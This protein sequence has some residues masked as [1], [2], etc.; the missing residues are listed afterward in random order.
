MRCVLLES[1]R[2][3]KIIALTFLVL[4]QLVFA[5]PVADY[6]I[7]KGKL[8]T[9]G[10]ARVEIIES[11]SEKFIVNL[12]YEIYKK[13]LV[14]IPDEDLKGESLFQLP[15]EFRD[16]RGYLELQ[17]KGTMQIEEAK[18]HFVKRLKWNNLTDAYQILIL[19][20]NGRSKIEII[21]HPSVKAAGWAKINI[22]FISK[23]PI[24]NGYQVLIDLNEK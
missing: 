4:S 16:E 6:T 17:T 5:G 3:K 14:P 13:I 2:M 22:V 23:A 20:N 8:H 7:Q 18:L 24:L 1:L 21:Y 19:P 9:G 10:K 12:S 15:S 11:S